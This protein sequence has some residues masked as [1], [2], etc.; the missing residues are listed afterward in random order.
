MTRLAPI[1]V[2]AAA[3]AVIVGALVY[4]GSAEAPTAPAR[5][6]TNPPAVVGQQQAPA[7]IPATPMPIVAASPPAVER[8][9]DLFARFAAQ[10]TPAGAMEAYRVAQQCEQARFLAGA[11]RAT[12]DRA[13]QNTLRSSTDVAACY[14]MEAV[15]ERQRLELL[16]QAVAAGV[17][18]A[19]ALYLAEGPF[20][21]PSALETR[22]DDP[23]VAEW[24]QRVLRYLQRDANRGDESA[25]LALAGVYED[26]TLV[27]G[28]D[29][30]KALVY[31]TARQEMLRAKG[32]VSPAAI[33]VY[34]LAKRQTPHNEV[35]AAIEAGK[36]LARQANS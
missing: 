33:A 31:L 35:A 25:I 4:N 5:P 30:G 8:P 32:K 11:S 14:G 1:G 7:K 24:K 10:K 13:Q 19:S 6:S 36:A 28:V 27:G 22:P 29:R 3:V 15:T 17:R 23:A 9:G 21:D 34:E 18:G 12:A 20:G 2:A 16:D 26:G